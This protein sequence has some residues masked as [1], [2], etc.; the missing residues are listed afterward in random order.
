MGTLS[1]R[2]LTVLTVHAIPAY[3]DSL[4]DPKTN[5]SMRS[6]RYARE[7]SPRP[8]GIVNPPPSS[9][10]EYPPFASNEAAA[11]AIDAVTP[12]AVDD[13]TFE[14]FRFREKEALR[15][16]E[17]VD[18]KVKTLSGPRAV[19]TELATQLGLPA[20]SSYDEVSKKKNI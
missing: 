4:N 2:I 9:A 5:L 20:S 8:A 16:T 14:W 12:A 11:P 1:H 18:D 13:K 19:T 15:R 7:P 17:E 6:S 3:F 10:T